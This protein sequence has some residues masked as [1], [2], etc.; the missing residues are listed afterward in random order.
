MIGRR[1][2]LTQIST[3][4]A[5]AGVSPV[6]SACKKNPTKK[7]EF[8]F[9]ICDWDLKLSGNP[10]AI[11]ATRA[12]G[13]DGVLVSMPFNPPKTNWGTPELLAET[14]TALIRTKLECASTSP[15]CNN[16]PLISTDGAVEYVIN[17]IKGAA[18]LGAKDILLPF[19]GKA[20][21]QAKGTKRIKEEYFKPLVKSL[22]K[23]TPVAEKLGIK[24]GMENS[25]NAEDNLRVIDAVASPSLMVYF[26]IMNF[27]YYGFNTVE[28]MKKLKGHIN[29]IH[30]KDIGHKFDSNSGKPQNMPL[31]FETIREIGYK[32]WLVF[33]THGFNPQK[34]GYSLEDLIKYNM[35]YV[36]NSPLYK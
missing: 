33:E 22:K 4:A 23:I 28:E 16:Y 30:L 35:E 3:L 14:K 9:G 15:M 13:L 31:V 36:K 8:K 12:L 20:N 18:A 5:L 6:I 7:P 25:I 27:T 29:Q 34:A 1:K 17:S 19:Y 10:K 24:I 26:D 11:D 32:G 21:L 2:F